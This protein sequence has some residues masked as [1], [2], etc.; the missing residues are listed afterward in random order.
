[1][2]KKM[3]KNNSLNNFRG[4]VITH[5]DYIKERQLKHERL[6]EKLFEKFECQFKECDQRFD[7][8]NKRLDI[9]QGASE[10]AKKDSIKAMIAGGGG[11][12]AGII[13]LILRFFK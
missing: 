3:V 2:R 12:L 5:L 1:M 8:I 11:G 13:S 10:V 9:A 6:L 7:G 4:K